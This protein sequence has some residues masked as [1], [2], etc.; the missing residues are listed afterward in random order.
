[1]PLIISNKPTF[2]SDLIGREALRVNITIIIYNKSIVI[3]DFLRHDNNNSYDE[4]S[5]E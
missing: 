3:K 4:Y 5:I 1:M 2:F